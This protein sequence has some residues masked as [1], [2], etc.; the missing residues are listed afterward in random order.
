CGLTYKEAE[1]VIK[2]HPL[3]RTFLIKQGKQSTLATLDLHEFD[4]E[5]IVLSG[6]SENVAHMHRIIEETGSEDPEVWLPLLYQTV[7]GEA[8]ANTA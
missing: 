6:T 2:L 1:E 3:S 5:M 7:L 8:T 4:K